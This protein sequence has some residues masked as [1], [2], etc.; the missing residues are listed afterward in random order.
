MV[1]K[2]I[3]L[4]ALLALSFLISIPAHADEPL[5]FGIK[6]GLNVSE[7]SFSSDVFDKTNQAGWFFGP[8]VKFT[9][10]VV[11]L[12]MDASVLY[13]M[14]SAK[15][16]YASE[17]QTVKQQ[18]ISI[19]INARYS[20]GLGSMANIFFFG[21]KEYDWN[22]KSTYALKNSNFSVN[23]GFGVTAFKHLQV[24]ANYNIACG[25][26]GDVT[27]KTTTDTATSALKKKD[28]HN[29]SWQ[30]GLAYFF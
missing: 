7:F 21:E 26:T 13:D 17:T 28:S 5:K 11:G 25:K 27:W 29:S 20:I 23:L 4:L 2:K 18:Q 24:S 12:G 6:A 3:I 30:L 22:M 9:L 14:R 10:P 15:L 16:E 1:M 19:P 8:T